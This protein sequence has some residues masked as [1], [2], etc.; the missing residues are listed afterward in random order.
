MFEQPKQK[1]TNKNKN[2][3]EMHET[4]SKT[5]LNSQ[6]KTK[7]IKQIQNMPEKLKQNKSNNKMYETI[8]KNVWKVKTNKI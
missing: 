2:K 8:P 6:N 1:Q 7:C 5:C 3:T 4:K